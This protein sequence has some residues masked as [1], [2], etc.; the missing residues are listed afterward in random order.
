MPNGSFEVALCPARVWLLCVVGASSRG[1]ILGWLGVTDVN[2]VQPNRS[3]SPE[4]GGYRAV[5]C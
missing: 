1:G 2:G 4:M 5:D 3:T